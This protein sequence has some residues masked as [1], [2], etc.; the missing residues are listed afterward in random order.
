VLE[1]TVSASFALAKYDEP[2]EHGYPHGPLSGTPVP[3]AGVVA[4]VHLQRA[5]WLVATIQARKI[6]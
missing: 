4:D 6:V 2:I 3:G 5:R 1:C